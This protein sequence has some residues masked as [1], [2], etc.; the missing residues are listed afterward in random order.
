MGG[1]T[2]G[3][4]L[5]GEVHLLN[6]DLYTK[7]V[8]SG[9]LQFAKI[10]NIDL[11]KV[12][13]KQAAQFQNHIITSPNPHISSTLGRIRSYHF[14][15]GFKSSLVGVA[16]AALPALLNAQFREAAGNALGA[17]VGASPAY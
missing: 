10:N 16:V 14:S 12:T 1:F 15:V 6:H 7:S 8:R 13:V 4:V 17:V 11:A 3:I 5:P 2:T 9:L